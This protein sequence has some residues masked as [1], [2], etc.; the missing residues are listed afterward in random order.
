MPD[1]TCSPKQRRVDYHRERSNE[2]RNKTAVRQR[3]PLICE[4]CG[5]RLRAP[6]PEGL[7]GFCREEALLA[8]GSRT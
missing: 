5:A 7:C 3:Q 1:A 2:Q 8:E 4:G 6:D